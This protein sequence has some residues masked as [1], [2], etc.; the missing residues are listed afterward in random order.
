[1]TTTP[2]PN[3]ESFDELRGSLPD[4]HTEVMTA[5]QSSTVPNTPASGAGRGPTD[6][7]KYGGGN[8]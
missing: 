5:H 7:Q 3:P 4:H 6:E 8:C 1:M 2:N